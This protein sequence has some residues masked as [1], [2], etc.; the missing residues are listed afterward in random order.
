MQK[1][2]LLTKLCFVLLKL[3]AWRSERY[4]EGCLRSCESGTWHEGEKIKEEK[5]S[6]E[7]NF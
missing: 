7:D 6:T 2:A 4:Y 1:I 3:E 5:W